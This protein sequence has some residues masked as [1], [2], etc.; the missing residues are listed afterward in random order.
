[1]VIQP[2]RSIAS[3]RKPVHLGTVNFATS[4]GTE[5]LIPITTEGFVSPGGSGKAEGF[6]DGE[7][8]NLALAAA[9]QSLV[10]RYEGIN[11]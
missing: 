6:A 10:I 3:C 8:A 9:T 5:A 4:A 1:M 11:A 7:W 2:R